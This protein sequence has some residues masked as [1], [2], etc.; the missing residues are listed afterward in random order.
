[1]MEPLRGTKELVGALID[2]AATP[3]QLI[4]RLG[5]DPSETVKSYDPGVY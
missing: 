4:E 5:I 2:E 1:M 3:R